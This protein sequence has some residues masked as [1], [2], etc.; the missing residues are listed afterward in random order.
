M[1]PIF[2][3]FFHHSDYL[4][5]TQHMVKGAPPFPCPISTQQEGYHPYLLC[6]HFL[7]NATRRGLSPPCCVVPILTQQG[8][9]CPSP[10]CSCFLFN[11]M[12]RGKPPLCCIIPIST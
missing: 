7:F 8:G 5:G 6:C 11:A 1:C 4:T 3:S 10:S 9:Y 12:R 2:F